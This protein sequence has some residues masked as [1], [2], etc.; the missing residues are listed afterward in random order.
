MRVLGLLRLQHIKSLPS[1]V[2]F[3]QVPIFSS[4]RPAYPISQLEISM[5]LCKHCISGM[6]GLCILSFI[7]ISYN[8]SVSRRYSWRYSRRSVN[9]LAPWATLP[10]ADRCCTGKWEKFNGVDAYV[11]TPTVDYP[12]D[13][14]LLY[15]TDAFGPQLKNNQ[16]KPMSLKW[17]LCF[18]DNAFDC[19]A[20]GRWL[21]SQRYRG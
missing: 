20:F 7:W 16:V 10:Y 8:R 6:H 17:N 14:V 21:C 4:L 2:P 13:K 12:K 5:S 11:A 15:L 3:L 9:S 18:F 19:L 1:S